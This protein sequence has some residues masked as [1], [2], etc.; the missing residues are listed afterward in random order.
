MSCG[1]NMRV[2]DDDW[3]TD[4]PLLLYGKIFLHR[5]GTGGVGEETIW[6]IG[7][8]IITFKHSDTFQNHY[9]H[10]NAVNFHN[11]RRKSLIELEETWYINRC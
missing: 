5:S 3:T 7:E 10:S 8:E 11:A 1:G 6:P 2:T 9:K 4:R